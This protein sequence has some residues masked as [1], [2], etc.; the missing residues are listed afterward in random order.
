MI[1]LVNRNAN[2]GR[3]KER[4]TRVEAELRARRLRFDVR[5][6]SSLQD[7]PGLIEDHD[8]V[9]AAGG[10]G[11]VHGVLNALMRRHPTAVLGAIGLGSS[12][13]FHKPFS[14]EC[15]IAE[16]PVRMDPARHST[17]DVGKA[18]LTDPVG[19]RHIRY[20]CLNASVGLVAESNA[21][22]NGDDRMLLWLKRRNVEAAILYAALV[23]LARFRPVRAALRLDEG[24]E[25]VMSFAALGILKKVHF[26]GGLRYDTPVRPD[27]GLF[28][29]NLC[30][31]TARSALARTLV[32]LYRGRFRGLPGAHCWRARRIRILPERPLHLEMD[33]EVS[34]IAAAELLVV[35]RALKICG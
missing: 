2:G 10:D 30:A 11:T 9:V 15:M 31:R 29:V 21:F 14:P 23:N 22:F 34:T 16:A 4:W 24:P 25:R 27:D 28:D 35:P 12:N 33:G 6:T 13:D 17:V 32:N 1:I 19:R 18:V 8:V 5:Y 7:V 26:A 3:A 20:F